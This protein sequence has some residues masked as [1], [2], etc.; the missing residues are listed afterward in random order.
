MPLSH[1]LDVLGCKRSDSIE[2]IAKKFRRAA[3]NVH[4]DR[5]GGNKEEM[6]KLTSAY[7]D[8]KKKMRKKLAVEDETKDLL[9]ACSKFAGRLK[10]FKKKIARM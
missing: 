7:N 6:Q 2:L 3:F 10:R 5:G 8:I 1:S 9:T 4:P